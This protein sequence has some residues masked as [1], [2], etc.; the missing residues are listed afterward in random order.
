MSDIEVQPSDN[1]ISDNEEDNDTSAGSV[2]SNDESD[3]SDSDV[4]NIDD[5]N[6]DEN[7]DLQN[8]GSNDAEN[9]PSEFKSNQKKSKKTKNVVDEDEDEEL[10]YEDDNFQKFNKKV[11]EDIISKYHP[12]EFIANYDEVYNL[13]KVNRN[14]YGIIDDEF[15]KTV[16]ILSKYEKTKLIGIRSKQLL[17]GAEPLISVDNQIIDTNLIAQKELEQKLLPFIIK[18]PLPNGQIEYWKIQDLENIY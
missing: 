1:E 18:R 13:C 7:D 12:E 17:E 16:P 9:N 10:E 4:S 11:K 15:H 3:V 6:D 8:N 2:V 14:K 5:E